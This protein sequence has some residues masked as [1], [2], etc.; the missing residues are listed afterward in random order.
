[1]NNDIAGPSSYLDFDGLRQLKSSAHR[2]DIV[3]IKATAKQFEALFIQSTLKAM[4]ESIEKSE[5]M[6]SDTGEMY[7]ALYDKELAQILA[8]RGIFGIADLLGRQMGPK[9]EPVPD[10]AGVTAPSGAT[11]ED[12]SG[13]PIAPQG[14][15]PITRSAPIHS[16][17]GSKPQG[18]AL[19]PLTTARAFELRQ[20]TLP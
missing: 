19:E 18:M 12:A 2:G 17:Q 6:S 13:R 4:R 14:G 7:E 5:L 15:L 9:S 10:K 20:R 1:M 16:L 11:A 8:N 3:A